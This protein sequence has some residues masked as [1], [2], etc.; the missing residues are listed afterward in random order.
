MRSRAK[1][2]KRC[3]SRARLRAQRVEDDPVLGGVGGRGIRNRA[4]G[5]EF[6][7]LVHQQRRVAAVVEDQVGPV[8]TLGRPVE[9]AVGEA[10]VLFE[11]LALP[12]EHGYPGGGVDRAGGPDDDGRRGFILRREDVAA[13]PPHLRPE[14]HERLDQHGRL[15]RHVERARDARAAQRL[16]RTELLAQSHEPRHLVLGEAQLVPARLSQREVGDLELERA[17]GGGGGIGRHPPIVA[18]HRSAMTGP[19]AQRL[20]GSPDAVPA[21]QARSVS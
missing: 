9:D 16:E 2:V 11:G 19:D 5:L 17:D 1:R 3:G 13:G 18:P 8:G 20:A 7:A 12:R 4:G 6:H 15:H 10:P 14:R 21:G